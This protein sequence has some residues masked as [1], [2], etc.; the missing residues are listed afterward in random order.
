MDVII[1]D[2]RKIIVQGKVF[3]IRAKE[4]EARVPNFQEDNQDDLSSDEEPQEADNNDVASDIDRDTSESVR[5]LSNKLKDRKMNCGISSLHNTYS[6]KTK[7][8]GSILDLMDELVKV[9]QTMGYKME[10]CV[11]DIESI[12]GSKGYFDIVR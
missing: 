7:V 4:L 12:I 11:K 3:Y 8:G 5:S 1:N 10:G 2:T 6:Q 9:G